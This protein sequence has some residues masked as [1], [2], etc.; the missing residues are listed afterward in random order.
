MKC[1]HYKILL[2][3]A[4]VFYNFLQHITSMKLSKTVRGI[5]RGLLLA[6]RRPCRSSVPITGAASLH[7][8]RT[9]GNARKEIFGGTGFELRHLPPPAGAVSR[10]SIAHLS[11]ASDAG[12]R[13]LSP[14]DYHAVADLALE[15]LQDMMETVLNDHDDESLDSDFCV[16]CIYCTTQYGTL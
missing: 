9:A 11:S 4:S 1:T 13:E 8:H 7:T 5:S 6:P 10:A 16:S 2:Q 12:V 3:R 15:E 14:Q